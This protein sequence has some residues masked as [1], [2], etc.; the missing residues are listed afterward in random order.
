[1]N[2][3]VSYVPNVFF[4]KI[5]GINGNK[6]KLYYVNRNLIDKTFINDENIPAYG[7]QLPKCLVG[8]LV[9]SKFCKPRDSIDVP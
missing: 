7:S 1:M 8:C 5:H 3:R 6:C 9:V 4:M 2:V